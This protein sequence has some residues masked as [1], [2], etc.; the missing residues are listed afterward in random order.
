V[1]APYRTV[2]GQGQLGGEFHGFPFVEA[3]DDARAVAKQVTL[4]EDVLRHDFQAF[5]RPFL[6]VALPDAQVSD[7]RAAKR[8]ELAILSSSAGLVVLRAF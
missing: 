2:E 7:P 5:A 6:W 8:L 1:A 4:Q 3:I